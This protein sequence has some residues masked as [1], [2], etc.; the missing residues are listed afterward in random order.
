[1]GQTKTNSKRKHTAMKRLK[2]A[3][4]AFVYDNSNWK[5]GVYVFLCTKEEISGV[6]AENVNEGL[7]ESEHLSADGMAGLTLAADTSA[8]RGSGRYMMWVDTAPGEK[9]LCTVAHEAVHVAGLALS[10]RGVSCNIENTS[11]SECIA[12]LV[13]NIV[14]FTVEK[15]IGMGIVKSEKAAK[16]DS[17]NP[18]KTQRIAA[19]K[20]L[21]NQ[22]ANTQKRPRKKLQGDAGTISAKGKHHLV[23]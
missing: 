4:K 13:E 7:P 12:Y 2:A 22:R 19:G 3:G 11:A 5:F 20:R 10:D 6:L 15:L 21:S 14:S 16:A 17:R 8:S 1:M 18:E 23:A 9:C